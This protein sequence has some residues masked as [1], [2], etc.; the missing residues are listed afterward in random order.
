MST[1]SVLGAGPAGAAGSTG[2]SAPGPSNPAGPTAPA[3]AFQS[4]LAGPQA[5]GAVVFSPLQPAGCPA[6]LGPATAPVPSGSLGEPLGRLLQRGIKSP[7]GAASDEDPLDP[8]RRH[9]AALQASEMLMTG[10]A[11]ASSRPAPASPP[12]AADRALAAVSLEELLPVL[13]R[14]IAWSGDGTRGAARLEIGAG[15]LAGATLLIAADAGR[16]RVHLEVPAGVDA[17]AW[18]DRIR[19]QLESRRIVADSVEVS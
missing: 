3:G 12:P 13:V 1:S 9:R 2:C 14:R 18:R 17:A 16:V 15:E 6:A 10:S 8:L 5:S 19:R 11:S 4:L 7:R